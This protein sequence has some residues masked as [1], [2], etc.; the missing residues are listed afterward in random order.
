MSL[1]KTIEVNNLIDL[2]GKFLTEKQL[3]IVNDYFKCDCSLSEIA[4][5]LNITKQAVKYSINLALEKLQELDS[6]LHLREIKDKLTLLLPE[7]DD[8]IQK[9]LQAIINLLGE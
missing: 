1:E 9:K 6:L 3:N 5:N 8:E 4:D 7:T 2:Y